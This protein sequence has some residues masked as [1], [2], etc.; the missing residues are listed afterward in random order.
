MRLWHV[1]SIPFQTPARPSRSPVCIDLGSHKSGVSRA[2]ISQRLPLR[3]ELGQIHSQLVNQPLG[4]V[5]RILEAS[6]TY[7]LCGKE[8]CDEH[9]HGF[10]PERSL[11]TSEAS[12][13]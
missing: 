6:V 7:S 9:K 2:H 1:R 13:K 4:D 10:Y 3:G 11:E 12:S 5:D 8:V